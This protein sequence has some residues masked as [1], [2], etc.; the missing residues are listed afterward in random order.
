MKRQIRTLLC[1]TSIALSLLTASCVQYPTE[2]R[3]VVDQRP[4]IS[5]RLAERT[6]PTSAAR[7]LVDGLDAGPL[8]QFVDGSA[9]LRVTS[10]THKVRVTDGGR[11]LLDERVY[12]GDGVSRSF[13]L[14]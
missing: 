8:S 13:L 6:N 4:Q 11:I 2:N 9:A 1:V 10:G 7:V 3:S 14:Q 5:F 12:L